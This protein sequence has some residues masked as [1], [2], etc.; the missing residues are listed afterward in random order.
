MPAALLSNDFLRAG[1]LAGLMAAVDVNSVVSKTKASGGIDA[2]GPANPKSVLSITPIVPIAIR[3]AFLQFRGATTD[4]T[5]ESLAVVESVI[6]PES[7]PE[8]FVAEIIRA[9][10]A[11]ND[12]QALWN[13]ACN[14]FQ[15]NEYIRG[16]VLSIGAVSKAP[17]SQ[18]LYLQVS[19]ARNFEGFFKSLRSLYREIVAPF[20]VAYWERTIAESTGL[21]RTAQAYTER[22]L[23]AA[24]GTPEGTRRLLAALRFC[25]GL[26]LPQ[27][28][29]DWLDSSE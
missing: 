2:T 25:L 29:M 5:M 20:F 28:A 27:D 19:V 15:A 9:L 13:D 14:A 18:S 24:D 12:W 6:P 26:K 17:T 7:Q 3:L 4:S 8:G 10:V 11:D 21:F 16:C 22:Q 1:Q 23:Q